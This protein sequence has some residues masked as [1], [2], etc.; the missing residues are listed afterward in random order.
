MEYSFLIFIHMLGATIWAGGHLVLSLAILPQALRTKDAEVVKQFEEKF[1]RLGIPAL[2]IQ[3]L[4]G[5]RLAYLF[6]PDVSSWWGFSSRVSTHI[7][8]KFIL[9]GLTLLLA[10]HARI[11]LIPRLQSHRL[12]FLAFHIVAVTVLAV[13]FVGVGVSIRVGGFF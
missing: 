13:L 6:L 8:L 4:T 12:N 7:T 1:E 10:L 5:L 2:L 3:I 9:L 11:R